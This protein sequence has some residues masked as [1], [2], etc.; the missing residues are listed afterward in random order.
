MPR[1]FH[2]VEMECPSD[3]AVS[4]EASSSHGLPRLSVPNTFGFFPSTPKKPLHH[5]L[6]H[7]M[8]KKW[9][10]RESEVLKGSGIALGHRLPLFHVEFTGY[11]V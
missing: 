5:Q 2:W 7:Q 1:E 11:K 3:C 6:T 10:L 4:K 8:I 9:C